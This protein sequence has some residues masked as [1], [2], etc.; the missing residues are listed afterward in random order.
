MRLLLICLHSICLAQGD[1]LP[2]FTEA[3]KALLLAN[4]IDFLSVNFYT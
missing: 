3:E 2:R 1:A 4:K